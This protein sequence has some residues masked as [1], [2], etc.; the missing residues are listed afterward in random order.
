MIY[1]IGSFLFVDALNDSFGLL[2]RVQGPK[3]SRRKH[4]CNRQRHIVWNLDKEL[5]FWH[6]HV[7]GIAKEFK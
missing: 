1:T 3:G 5:N 6:A 7:L 4:G 2:D